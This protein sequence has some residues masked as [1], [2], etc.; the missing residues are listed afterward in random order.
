MGDGII[1]ADTT[2][3]FWEL[4]HT[5]NTTSCDTRFHTQL[6]NNVCFS[7]C[8]GDGEYDRNIGKCYVNCEEKYN[9]AKPYLDSSTD[10][11][12]NYVEYHSV[13]GSENMSTM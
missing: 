11:C 13:A 12:L 5:Y 4:N 1:N 6:D 9:G 7:A 3:L 10:T 8:P 2:E